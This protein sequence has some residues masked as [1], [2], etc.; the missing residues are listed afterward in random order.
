[1]KPLF[2]HKLFFPEC[3]FQSRQK[4]GRRKVFPKRRDSTKLI[5]VNLNLIFARI[6]VK[7]EAALIKSTIGFY[8]NA[9]LSTSK[10]EDQEK[11]TKTDSNVEVP[12]TGTSQKTRHQKEQRHFNQILMP[13]TFLL[14]F[15]NFFA[16]YNRILM[17]PTF[18][19]RN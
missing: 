1:M 5:C 10:E 19:L 11:K 18:E 6:V 15:F 14:R 3:I 7:V 9:P 13:P 12:S 2:P 8:S 16:N 17:P 4:R